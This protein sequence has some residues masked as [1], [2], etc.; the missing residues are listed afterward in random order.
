M[1]S[2]D[3]IKGKLEEVGG[4]IKEGVGDATDNESLEAEGHG[5]QLS[6]KGKQVGGDV[7]EGLGNVKDDVTNN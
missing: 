1:V 2:G 6:G 3:K 4:K 5:D 7:K